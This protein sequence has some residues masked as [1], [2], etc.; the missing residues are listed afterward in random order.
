MSLS[1]GVLIAL[2][3]A[4]SVKVEVEV[5]ILGVELVWASADD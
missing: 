4:A 3:A 1:P 2:P 5:W